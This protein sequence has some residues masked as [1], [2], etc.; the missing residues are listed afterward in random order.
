MELR[1][2]QH[3]ASREQVAALEARLSILEKT[4]LFRGGPVD[5]QVARLANTIKSET[6][7]E[8]LIDDR[9]DERSGAAWTA[10]DRLVA[11]VLAII[12]IATFLINVFH[13]FAATGGHP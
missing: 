4:A 13:P 6:E 5:V 1:L 10:R 8:A 7:L 9:L 2:I 12:A 3:L 11:G